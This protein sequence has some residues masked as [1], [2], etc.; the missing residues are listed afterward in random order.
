MPIP[1]FQSL[2]RP[3]LQF[4]V[5]GNAHSIRDG[6]DHLANQFNLTSEERKELLPSGRQEVFTNRVAW[7]KTH[8]RM[9]GLIEA[10]S[11]GVFRITDRGQQILR[12]HPDRVDLRILRE[13]PGYLEARDSKKGKNGKNGKKDIEE[14]SSDADQTPEEQIET[15]SLALRNSLGEDILAKMKAA[16]PAFFERLVVEL[17]VRMGYG[18]TRKDAGRAIGRSGDEGIDGIIKEDRLGLDVIYI[19]AKKWEAT[20]GR[21]EIQKFAGALQGFR[22]KKGIFITTSDFSKEAEDYASRIDS[23]I[24]LID[25]ETL[26]NLMIDFGIGVSTVATYEVKKLD[27]DYFDEENG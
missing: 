25:G 9:A 2:M 1:D 10:P 24:V 12:V 4:A 27:N 13:Q 26:W 23:K 21:P 20:V 17:L 3:L 22:A 5:D 6:L 15:A 18:G 19:Q 11:R 16:S 8:L 14:D 7:A